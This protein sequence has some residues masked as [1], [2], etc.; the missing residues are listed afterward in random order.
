MS[1]AKTKYMVIV[2]EYFNIEKI[3]SPILIIFAAVLIWLSLKMT[4]VPIDKLVI[5]VS[6]MIIAVFMLIEGII[7][8]ELIIVRI[9]LSPYVYIIISIFLLFE[10]FRRISQNFT[11]YSFQLVDFVLFLIVFSLGIHFLHIAGMMKYEDS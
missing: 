10:S 1:K 11:S 5:G 6:V 3:F 8:K 2:D 9:G 7:K 4:S